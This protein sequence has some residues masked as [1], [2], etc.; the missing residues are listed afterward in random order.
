MYG[1]D[2]GTL[3][4]DVDADGG[5]DGPWT[6]DVVPSMTD[7]IELWQMA[8]VDLTAY[9]GATI[10]V[11]LRGVTGL[12]FTG[13]MAIDDVAVYELLADDLG[14][15]SI[16]GP[17]G[18][19]SLSATESVSITISNYGSSPQTGFDVSYTLD[20]G[21]PVV[22]TFT[23]TLGANS[24]ISF[25]FATP[26]DLS[27]PGPFDIDASTAL[28]T[29]QEPANDAAPTLTIAPLGASVTTYPAINDF[30]SGPGD[31]F[32]HGTNNTWAFG[33]PA[34]SVINSAASGVNAWVNGG[35]NGSYLNSDSS[36]VETQCGYDFTPLA[37]PTVRLRAWWSTESNFDQANLQPRA[38][39]GPP[40]RSSACSA[41]PTT[42]TTT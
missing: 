41:I 37:F 38:T 18:G 6:L 12:S 32:S 35:L 1:A 29:D 10:N 15:A 36:Y 39:T 22:E 24:S 34:K 13:D 9:V 2:M 25:I 26:V 30:E 40:G 21:V 23:G 4:V 14:V 17:V 11:R 19:C 8:T 28:A 33:T 31:W 5:G 16:D 7:N 42:G 3:H 27:G 20:G